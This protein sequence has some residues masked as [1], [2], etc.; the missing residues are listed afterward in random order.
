MSAISNRLTVLHSSSVLA[1]I[2][3][4]A[5]LHAEPPKPVSVVDYM[6]SVKLD[7]SFDNRKLLFL[8]NWPTEEY[9][10]TAEQNT[11]LLKHLLGD[12]RQLMLP[13]PSSIID[14]CKEFVSAHECH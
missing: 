11:K 2:C 9:K 8:T 4:C 1:F 13:F 3:V 6:K 10:G 5:V 14:G 12:H 7:S